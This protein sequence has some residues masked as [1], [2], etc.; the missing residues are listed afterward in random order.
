[1]N[2][3]TVVRETVPDVSELAL[4]DVWFGQLLLS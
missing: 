2:E 4:L 1:M 3:L